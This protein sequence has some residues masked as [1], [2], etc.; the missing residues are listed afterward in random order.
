MGWPDIL[1]DVKFADNYF[2][3]ALAESPL[4]GFPADKFDYDEDY[5]RL[6]L[7]GTF[8][9]SNPDL[10][11]FAQAGGKLIIVQGGNDV[12]EQAHAAI[13]YYQMV[14]RVMGGAGPTQA[15]ARLFVVPGM[16]HC[17]GGDGAFAIDHLAAIQAWVGGTAPAALIGAHVPAWED[18]NVAVREGLTA[19]P[20]GT[21]VT[22]TR[23]AYPY[24]LHAE[25]SGHGDV[26]DA[27]S[28]VAKG[29]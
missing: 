6:G 12:T 28:F 19:P 26:N 29:P 27:G 16:N 4:D 21:T 7:G 9:D 25:Y 1:E 22:F 14:E 20:P 2:R 10:R 18:L 17:S 15:F 13:D 11:K 8:V 23:P 3:F 5:K 24:P